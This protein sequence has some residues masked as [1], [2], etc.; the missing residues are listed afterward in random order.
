[1]EVYDTSSY[2]AISPYEL[3]RMFSGM[4]F[5]CPQ[6]AMLDDYKIHVKAILSEIVQNLM[7]SIAIMGLTQVVHDSTH[8]EGA[9]FDFISVPHQIM[10]TLLEGTFS[11]SSL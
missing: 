4:A 6:I 5:S 3:P 2:P 11:S 8:P 9:S 10:K 1:M 7:V